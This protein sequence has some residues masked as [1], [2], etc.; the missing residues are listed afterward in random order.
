M[1]TP[2]AG[3]LAAG[4]SPPTRATPSALRH[5][6][7]RSARLR[8]ATARRRARD[9]HAAPAARFAVRA[10]LPLLSGHV[11]AATRRP[12]DGDEVARRLDRV[13]VALVRTI[14]SVPAPGVAPLRRRDIALF[15]AVVAVEAG[16]VLL[17]AAAITR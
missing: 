3:G 4:T 14:R 8:A 10:P 5:A 15:A 1:Q 13:A 17:I 12:L 9:R 16:V 2:Q 7:I 6:R 11:V